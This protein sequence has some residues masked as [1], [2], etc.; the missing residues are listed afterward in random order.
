MTD[1]IV[2]RAGAWMLARAA[3]AGV[4]RTVQ[5]VATAYDG[6]V[7]FALATGRVTADPFALQVSVAEAV[8]AAVRD[9]ARV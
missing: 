1:A 7:C 6:D 5:P 8:A 3:T 9:G 2:D 4:A